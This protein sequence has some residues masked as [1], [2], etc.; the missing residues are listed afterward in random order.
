MIVGSEDPLTDQAHALLDSLG[1]R[2]TLTTIAGAGHHP[3]VT[4]AGAL[5]RAIGQHPLATPALARRGTVDTG[6]GVS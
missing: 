3:Q 5:A 6:F 2:V 1:P 4:H